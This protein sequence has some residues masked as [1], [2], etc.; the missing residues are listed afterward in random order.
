MVSLRAWQNEIKEGGNKATLTADDL[1]K[2]ETDAHAAYDARV[3]EM[4][5]SNR[6][7]T[8]HGGNNQKMVVSETLSFLARGWEDLFKTTVK[9]YADRASKDPARYSPLSYALQT[10]TATLNQR[11]EPPR[12]LPYNIRPRLAPAA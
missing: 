8:P 4:T 7:V 9:E 2:A 12:P 11:S 1:F 10:I 3:R 6:G 5:Y